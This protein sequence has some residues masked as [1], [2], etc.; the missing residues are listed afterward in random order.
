MIETVPCVLEVHR[1][2]KVVRLPDIRRPEGTSYGFGQFGEEPHPILPHGRWGATPS[3]DLLQDSCGDY[4]LDEPITFRDGSQG[5]RYNIMRKPIREIGVHPEVLR[6]ISR[7]AAGDSDA[8]WDLSD[9]L[10]AHH[11]DIVRG[12]AEEVLESLAPRET[13]VLKSYLGFSDDLSQ[14]ELARAIVDLGL[15]KKMTV[16]GI[17]KMIPR[18]MKKLRVEFRRR[19]NNMNPELW[20]PVPTRPTPT[21]SKM[22]VIDSEYWQAF[23]ETVEKEW[24]KLIAAPRDE[25]IV[26]ILA[27]QSVATPAP[28]KTRDCKNEECDVVLLGRRRP[29]FR[30]NMERGDPGIMVTCPLCCAFKKLG[31]ATLCPCCITQKALNGY[32]DACFADRLAGEWLKRRSPR[33]R[34]VESF[35]E[36]VGAAIVRQEWHLD[37]TAANVAFNADVIYTPTGTPGDFRV[38]SSDSKVRVYVEQNDAVL[39]LAFLDVLNPV[40]TLDMLNGAADDFAVDWQVIAPVIPEHRDWQQAV[41]TWKP[42]QNDRTGWYRP[43]RGADVVSTA[44]R[45]PLESALVPY[46]GVDFTPLPAREAPRNAGVGM[47]PEEYLERQKFLRGQRQ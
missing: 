20:Q 27:K 42:S 21:K 22:F 46:E 34:A 2:G 7:G 6:E 10:L 39:L 36:R 13:Y 17:K 44:V 45:L 15:A 3:E 31:Y 26:P 16:N 18:A 11:A 40:L 47:S 8:V 23:R 32:C 33:V 29:L 30:M 19:L 12:V 4:S 5:D 9:E 1:N 43:A 28:L 35:D 41:A 14:V 38:D 24:L 25:I 37:L